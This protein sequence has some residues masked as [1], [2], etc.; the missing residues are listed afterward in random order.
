[1]TCE[2]IIN[3]NFII[4]NKVLLEHNCFHATI[5]KQLQQELYRTQK[6]KNIYNLVLN[7]KCVL[8][9]T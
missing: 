9:S 5:V 3:L 8:T 4:H 1:M 6:A 2:N 7:T